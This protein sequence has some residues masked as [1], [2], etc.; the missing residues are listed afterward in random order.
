MICAYCHT[1]YSDEEWKQLPFMGSDIVGG[2]INEFRYC[3][4]TIH[5]DVCNTPICVPIMDMRDG[6]L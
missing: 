4:A 2:I 5:M 3:N 1:S 6:A